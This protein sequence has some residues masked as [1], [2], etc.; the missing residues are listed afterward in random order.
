MKKSLQNKLYKK[1]PKLF[2]Q[3][4]LPPTESCLYFGIETDDGW[5]DLIDN[6]CKCIQ[7]YIDMN[8]YL[9][10]PQV[11]IAQLKEKYGG[12]RYY[13]DNS[14]EYISGMISFAE[15]ISYETCEVCGKKGCLCSK[16][17]WMKTLC[18]DHMKKY[19]YKKYKEKE[20]T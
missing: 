4:D 9:N 10:I 8:P 15:Y 3:K 6:L 1:Y 18:K 11:E 20:Q 13:V 16:T 7:S 5:Y 12:L 14:N 19:G 2:V 17:G